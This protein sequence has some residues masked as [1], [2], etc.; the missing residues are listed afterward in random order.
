[1]VDI[2]FLYLSMLYCTG[3]VR[4]KSGTL[5]KHLVNSRCFFYT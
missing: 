4:L 2:Q 3:K 1:M 5:S